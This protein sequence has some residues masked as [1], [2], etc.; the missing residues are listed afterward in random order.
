EAKARS[1]ARVGGARAAGPSLPSH[2]PSSHNLGTPTR[3]I[4]ISFSASSLSSP[5]SRSSP[6]PEKK[7]RKTLES[8][9]SFEGESKV[10]AP[11]FIRKHIYP[12]TRI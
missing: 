2:P 8:G 4:V 1:R 10:D 3:P 11:Q 5:P 9:S 7:K 12:Y 6:E